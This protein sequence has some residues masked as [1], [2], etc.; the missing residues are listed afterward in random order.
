MVFVSILAVM[1]ARPS[2]IT[3]AQMKNALFLLAFWWSCKCG[4]V[5][6]QW[7]ASTTS[8]AKPGMERM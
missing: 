3:M 2:R 1:Q 8:T 6:L 7:R 5:E 4:Q